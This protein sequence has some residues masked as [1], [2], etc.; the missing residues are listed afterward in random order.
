MITVFAKITPKAEFYEDAKNAIL[1]IIP[2]T[3]LE[4]GCHTFNLYDHREGDV[5]ILCLFEIFNNQEAY[6]FHHHQD[7]T[8]HVFELYKNWLAIQPEIN[9]LNTID[10][11]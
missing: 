6:D 2:Q 5:N 4:S 7:Y 9:F 1:A 10:V 8:R 11:A 3:R